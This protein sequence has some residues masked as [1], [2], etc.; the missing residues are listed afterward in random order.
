MNRTMI[1]PMTCRSIALAVLLTASNLSTAEWRPLE[2]TDQ[3]RQRQSAEN[4]DTYKARGS[5]PP[6]GGYSRPLGDLEVRGTERP[7][8]NTPQPYPPRPAY[9]DKPDRWSDP[10]RR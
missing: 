6:L 1:R 9:G 5:T 2:T 4:Y 3:A 10:M 7:G 8:Y